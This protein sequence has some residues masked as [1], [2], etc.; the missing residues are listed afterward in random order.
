MLDLALSIQYHTVDSSGKGCGIM[1]VEETRVF[2][3]PFVTHI[4]YFTRDHPDGLHSVLP[5][6]WLLLFSLQGE[7]VLELP[8]STFTTQPG[9]ALFLPPGT[10]L[11][12]NSGAGWVHRFV[13]IQKHLDI[14]A[15]LDWPR[16]SGS[17]FRL[18]RV[19][20]S[21]LWG[22]V[23][24]AL[25]EMEE[26]WARVRP[27]RRD[28]LAFNLLEQVLLWLDGANPLSHP[29]VRD[30]RILDAVNYMRRSFA[31]HIVLADIARTAHLS[32]S[33]F[34]HLFHSLTGYSPMHYLE[35]VR[36]E[37]ARE[38]LLATQ[39][40]LAEIAMDCG[41]CNEFYMS[42]VFRKRFGQRPSDFRKHN[43][44]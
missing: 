8:D 32:P 40:T 30:P 31:E 33:R 36:L 19:Q 10:P 17:R 27:L 28:E 13:I 37:H 2:H 6:N 23:V 12:C 41:F 4:T 5:E 3:L 18:L 15:W 9:D 42:N 22:R 16:I 1:A 11:I 34:S 44:H 38:M 39:A 35:T 26:V 43:H 14:L 25:D 21:E 24:G 7:A 29:V 20:N